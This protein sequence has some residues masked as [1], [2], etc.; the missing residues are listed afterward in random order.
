MQLWK[1]PHIVFYFFI[2]FEKC[3]NFVCFVSYSWPVWSFWH[4]SGTAVCMTCSDCILLI[5]QPQTSKNPEV[6]ALILLVLVIMD[7][8]V[9]IFYIFT[10]WRWFSGVWIAWC[11]VLELINQVLGCS[12]CVDLR[13][14][15]P[16]TSACEA[17]RNEYSSCWCLWTTIFFAKLFLTSFFFLQLLVLWPMGGVVFYQFVFWS[18]LSS[19]SRTLILFYF[20]GYPRGGGGTTQG[21]YLKRKHGRSF[22]ISP[23]DSMPLC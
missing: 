22:H 14:C 23:R 4:H 18:N 19:G 17:K 8:L 5:L 16:E 3:S 21:F 10:F 11:S 20:F 2:F 9:E 6:P 13:M 7:F 15:K 1:S 12:L